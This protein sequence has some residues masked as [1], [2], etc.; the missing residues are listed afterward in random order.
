MTRCLTAAVLAAALLAVAGVAL[1][2]RRGREMAEPEDVL[3]ADPYLASLQLPVSVTF[4]HPVRHYGV[5]LS[6]SRQCPECLEAEAAGL[7]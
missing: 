3:P 5:S 6:H 2:Y 4:N 1:G 7:R